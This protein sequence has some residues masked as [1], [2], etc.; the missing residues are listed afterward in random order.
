M[1]FILFVILICV[2]MDTHVFVL[3]KSKV[4]VHMC[5]YAWT[6]IHKDCIHLM[7]VFVRMFAFACPCVYTYLFV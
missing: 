3:H 7:C 6:L 4:C 2:C 1:N 5:V